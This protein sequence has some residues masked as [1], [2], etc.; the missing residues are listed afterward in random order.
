MGGGGETGG[1]GQTENMVSME[2]LS[3]DSKMWWEVGLRDKKGFYR[4]YSQGEMALCSGDASCCVTWGGGGKGRGR[5]QKTE[6]LRKESS[7]RTAACPV[8]WEEEA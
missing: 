8:S 3:F 4:V 1:P 2:I 6:F 5:E 7:E